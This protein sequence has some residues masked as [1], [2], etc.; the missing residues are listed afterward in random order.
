MERR[1]LGNP[2]LIL[3]SDWHLREDTP[4]CR[5]D[6]Y[7]AAQWKKVDFVAALQKK[8]NC[9]VLHGGDLYDHWK[10][11][12][13]LIRET[14]LHLPESFCTIYGQHDLPQHSLELV[15]KCGI[16]VLST[17]GYLTILAG[18]HWGNN[19]EVPSLIRD[20][21]STRLN[22]QI[23]VW[24]VMNYSGAKP[25]PGCLDSSALKL[26]QKYP[27][28]GLILTGDNHKPFVETYEGRLLVNPGS[29]MRMDADQID[30]KPRVYLWYSATNTV[31]PV[32]LP[33]DEGVVTREHIEQ[34][35]QREGRIDA[36]VSKLDLKW[37]G[38]MDYL[39]NVRILMLKNKTR[40][41]VQQIVY[42]ALD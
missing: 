5:L 2:D 33:I 30:F 37:K 19:P 25:W 32:Y 17:A 28:F 26:L 6:D 9:L 12:P 22:F 3:T 41:S 21:S 40:T 36:Y 11:S 24:H 16:N 20:Y 8:Y 1:V 34:K 18:T 38:E 23:L 35:V 10:P 4:T 13:N 14:M 29:L 7:W 15:H 31:T 27:Q 39:E 42:K